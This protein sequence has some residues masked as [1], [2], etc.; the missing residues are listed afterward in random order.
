VLLVAV[1]VHAREGDG[2][3]ALR[4]SGQE[5]LNQ[6]AAFDAWRVRGEQFH[7]YRLP[8][9]NKFNQV[10]VKIKFTLEQATKAQR[11]NRGIT[12]LFL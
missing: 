12:V 8:T 6:V 4:P 5:L 7:S 1:S 3:P 11:G 2:D 10:N 9:R